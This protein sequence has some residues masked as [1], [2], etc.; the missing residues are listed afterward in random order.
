MSTL[1]NAA[2]EYLARKVAYEDGHDHCSKGDR[3]DLTIDN[4]ETGAA[5]S[6][7]FVV[8]EIYESSWYNGFD[9]IL[10][11]LVDDA[12]S[13]L[14]QAVLACGGSEQPI[15]Y[16][17]DV[18][19][20]GIGYLQF[21]INA[22]GVY[23]DL[24]D[25]VDEG[26]SISLTGHSLGGALAQW[27]AVY[28]RSWGDVDRIDALVTFNSP[29]ISGVT[30]RKRTR[31]NTIRHYLNDGDFVSM[32]GGYY[33]SGAADDSAVLFVNTEVC[34]SGPLEYAA[35][36][37]HSDTL[38]FLGSLD[39]L[40]R[41]PY[42]TV[43]AYGDPDEFAR[44]DFSYL[45]VHCDENILL[46][47]PQLA[48]V[49]EAV[50]DPAGGYWMFNKQYAEFISLLTVADRDAANQLVDREGTEEA[51]FD[52]LPDMWNVALNAAGT[53]LFKADLGEVILGERDLTGSD[54]S[55]GNDVIRSLSSSQAGAEPF[56][57][58]DFTEQRFIELERV[59][60]S[61]RLTC[62][63]TDSELVVKTAFDDGDDRWVYFNIPALDE[64]DRFSLTAVANGSG[65]ELS[66]AN[67]YRS[68]DLWCVIDTREDEY[69]LS[70]SVD[71][72]ITREKAVVLA[73][74]RMADDEVSALVVYVSDIDA[75][76]DAGAITVRSAAD[77]DG[78]EFRLLATDAAGVFAVEIASDELPGTGSG[79]R[80]F[81]AYRDRDD[82]AGAVAVAKKNV[83]VPGGDVPRQIPSADGIDG[84]GRAD[85][86]MTVALSGHDAY[87]ATGA[88]LIG[89]DQTATWG[90]LSVRGEDWEL[91]GTGF[92][93]AGETTADV[94]L[95]SAD[96]TV[97]AW[98]TNVSGRVAG[99]TTVGSFGS[100]T[101]VLALGD[102]DG[103]GQTD[104]LLRNDNGAVGG[105]FTDGRGWAYFQS[106]GDEWTVAAVG[107]LNGDGRS[108]LV[109]KHDAGFAGSWL[110]QGDGTMVW[111]D[112]DTLGDGFTIA[113]CGDF[114]GDGSCDVLLRYGDYYGA[115]LVEDG[116][117][118]SWMGLGDLG[119]V[120]VEQIGDFDGD[121]RADL[122]IR[123]ASG[124]LGAQLVK[125]E[126][127]LEWKYYGSVGQEWSTR[128]SAL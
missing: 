36:V 40:V 60:V 122:R 73:D 98:T 35:G 67:Y 104:L 121:G 14:K 119:D 45:T 11:E 25:L 46:D 116:G 39:D 33:V 125:G 49:L 7:H 117:V 64:S 70:F 37:Q 74:L 48:A 95:K 93:A 85:I 10:L 29:G 51:R 80:L 50:P 79:D 2:Y 92:F 56:A 57:L 114:D 27:F 38:F 4:A 115:W 83:A 110:T 111:A 128:F 96:N 61:A 15:D 76:G 9:A 54:G 8:R 103:D 88:W 34:S 65:A 108:D 82:G 127:T 53:Q 13:S 69:A 71:A 112:L 86:V 90:D 55:F 66:A 19:P 43:L 81:I 63:E 42:L 41:D 18:N 20:L 75:G 106:L 120:T 87:G 30:A 32:A 84:D 58:F 68:G 24:E 31:I 89:D 77:P 62:E 59:T 17:T 52:K 94:Y 123:T 21:A 5:E 26:C 101:Q 47:H 28:A 99:W 23:D 91:F 107:D 118:K 3:L 6:W 100:D 109:L 72:G 126:D 97:G 44:D 102:F 1:S 16:L 113:G 12:G 78:A 22:G 105:H 124:D